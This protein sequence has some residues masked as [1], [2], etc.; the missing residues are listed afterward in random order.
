MGHIVDLVEL[1]RAS[2]GERH[3]PEPHA[4]LALVGA[5]INHLGKLGTGQARRDAPDVHQELPGL[6]DRKRYL[7]RI[8]ELHDPHSGGCDAVSRRA[9]PKSIATPRA[10]ARPRNTAR[11]VGCR[12]ATRWG[13]PP[14][15]A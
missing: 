9:Y 14:S 5:V 6:V 13:P 15:A 12:P 4:D 11:P 2:E 7:E 10:G 8:I 3:R 1:H